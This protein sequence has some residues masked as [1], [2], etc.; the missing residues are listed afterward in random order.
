MPGQNIIKTLFLALILSLIAA[1]GHKTG[2]NPA[3]LTKQG[4]NVRAYGAAGDGVNDD[5]EAIQKAI[6]SGNPVYIPSGVYVIDPSVSLILRSGVKIY[7]DGKDK[8]V[9]YAKPAG[10][11]IFRREFENSGV[12]RYVQNILIEELAVVMNHPPR[13]HRSNYYQIAFDFRNITRSMIR[14]CYAGNYNRGAL[15][16]TREDPPEHIDAIQGYGI[17]FGNVSAR[18]SYAGG[19]VN[20]VINSQVWGARKCIVNDDDMLSPVSAAHATQI[21]GNDV[22]ICETGISV[23]SEIT[24]GVDIRD[25]IVQAIKR[26]R[27]SSNTTYTYRIDGYN[28]HIGSGYT[29]VLSKD[30]DHLIYL[31]PKSE[32]NIIEPFQFSTVS[33]KFTDLGRGNVIRYIDPATN[34]YTELVGTRDRTGGIAKAWAVFGPD[35]KIL[36]SFNVLNVEKNGTGEFTLRFTPGLFETND[37]AVSGTGTVNDNGDPGAVSIKTQTSSNLR[38]TTYSISSSSLADFKKTSV[39]VW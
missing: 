19:E 36:G 9:L 15:R 20:A 5:T 17:V 12:N 23:E 25:N 29:E 28:N 22:Q 4:E 39:T 6:D 14:N 27:G 35:G 26:A 10:G 31:G 8:T 24:A 21:W 33:P 32:R 2:Q 38:I 18:S 34:R 16:E 13:A 1:C 7:G 30:A 11:S 37:Y 3:F